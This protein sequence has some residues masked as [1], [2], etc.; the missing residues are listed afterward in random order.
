MKRPTEKGAER[1]PVTVTLK[2]KRYLHKMRIYTDA[3]P[4]STGLKS[5]VFSSDRS[6]AQ[7]D[8]SN[9]K[10]FSISYGSGQHLTLDSWL[11]LSHLTECERWDH[12]HVCS[13][14]K[15]RHAV[16]GFPGTKAVAEGSFHWNW[17]C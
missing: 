1:T 16:E 13:Q 3:K 7:L 10:V 9:S 2:N 11:S 15:L 5:P 8:V 12:D 14:Q 4:V 6:Q 17:K